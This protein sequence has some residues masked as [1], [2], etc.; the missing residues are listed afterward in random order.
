MVYQGNVNCNQL[1]LPPDLNECNG[2][3]RCDE[4]ALCINTAGSYECRCKSGLSGNGY[5]CEG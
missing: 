4:N 1:F 5:W 3:H 2:P